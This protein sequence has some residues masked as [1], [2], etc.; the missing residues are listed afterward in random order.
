MWGLA[1]GLGTPG[2]G[3]VCLPEGWLRWSPCFVLVLPG[4]RNLLEGCR[5]VGLQL[6]GQGSV[7]SFAKRDP[8]TQA[9]RAVLAPGGWRAASPGS[10]PSSISSTWPGGVTLVS[11]LSAGPGPSPPPDASAALSRGSEFR[12]LLQEQLQ[13][14]EGQ[15][16]SCPD[17]RGFELKADTLPSKAVLACF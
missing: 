10:Y 16:R 12:E 9:K 6:E 7:S 2:G 4:L 1:W 17:L 15:G 13:R 8:R 14:W 3:S 11:S 5:S